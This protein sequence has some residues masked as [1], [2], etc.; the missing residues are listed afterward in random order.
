MLIL[1]VKFDR[2][3]MEKALT[4]MVYS[5]SSSF[6]SVIPL[7]APLLSPQ[8]HPDWSE[9]TPAGSEL[10]KVVLLEFQLD[11][12]FILNPGC[13]EALICTVRLS[14]QYI[15]FYRCEF[16][17]Q[18]W[19]WVFWNAPPS[20]NPKLHL[21]S[22]L[23]LSAEVA[24]QLSYVLL[25]IFITAVQGSQGVKPAKEKPS[26]FS[27]VIGRRRR[28]P[29]LSSHRHPACLCLLNLPV[30]SHDGTAITL[31]FSAD[32]HRLLLQQKRSWE[33]I[34]P[35]Q[36]WTATNQKTQESFRTLTLHLGRFKFGRSDDECL[37]FILEK[38]FIKQQNVFFP[39][40]MIFT[41]AV[42]EFF[43]LVAG[44]SPAVVHVLL[45]GDAEMATVV[46]EDC[47]YL[48]IRDLIKLVCITKKPCLAL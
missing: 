33:E 28:A 39:S 36:A 1:L 2:H 16:K 3:I 46:T 19:N 29:S 24:V 7:K 8:K 9:R 17:R 47:P 10:F 4:G 5:T 42:I 35:L 22:F 45:S 18:M 15:W 13:F 37:S 40:P 48:H 43:V 11:W 14:H 6:L 12:E 25:L 20:H 44:L 38:R 26:F 27:T 41:P 32:T 31:I 34:S 30:S 21:P 23:A